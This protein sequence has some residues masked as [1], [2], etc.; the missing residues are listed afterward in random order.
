M[1][2]EP[3]KLI[4]ADQ[5]FGHNTTSRC[6][7]KEMGLV[8]YALPALGMEALSLPTFQLQGWAVIERVEERGYRQVYRDSGVS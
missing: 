2:W 1:L 3:G 6:G 5:P 4:G 8:R 7:Q